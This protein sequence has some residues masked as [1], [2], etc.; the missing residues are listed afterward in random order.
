MKRQDFNQDWSYRKQGEEQIQ[1][2][3]L[4]HDAMIHDAR[5]PESPGTHA[6]AYFPGGVYVYEKSFDVPA[7][8]E[9]SG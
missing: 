7:G 4:P 5:D 9:N 2:V 1:E 6:N 8:W 3:T